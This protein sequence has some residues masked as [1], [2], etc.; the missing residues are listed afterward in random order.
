[1]IGYVL[2]STVIMTVFD[3]MYGKKI[4]LGGIIFNF[5]FSAVIITIAKVLFFS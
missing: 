5:I 2:L 1:M 4:R 3:L